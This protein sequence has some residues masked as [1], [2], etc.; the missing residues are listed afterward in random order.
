MT[1]WEDISLHIHKI[2]SCVLTI[3]FVELC[4]SRHHPPHHLQTFCS[5]SSNTLLQEVIVLLHL[6]FSKNKLDKKD[7]VKKQMLETG[8]G[9]LFSKHSTSDTN[10][11]KSNIYIA[12]AKTGEQHCMSVNY[13]FQE[14]MLSVQ[15]VINIYSAYITSCSVTFNT[16]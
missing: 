6:S 7:T 3:P 1:I 14:N 4:P 10:C 9:V 15:K 11:I 8:M 16:A 2:V 12:S 5:M 13:K